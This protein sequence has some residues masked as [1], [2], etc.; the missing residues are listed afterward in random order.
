MVTPGSTAPCAS[1]TVPS[2]VPLIACDWA[3]ADAA[4]V[5]RASAR[6][7]RARFRN[8]DRLP[9]FNPTVYLGRGACPFGAR[10]RSGAAIAK[11]PSIGP[12]SAL[13]QAVRPLSLGDTAFAL[14]P[15]SN[16]LV[17]LFG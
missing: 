12:S 16:P 9:L 4:G 13:R 14:S 17:D 7:R 5:M 3:A 11:A 10:A 1:T 2:I 8:M 6:T 15:R